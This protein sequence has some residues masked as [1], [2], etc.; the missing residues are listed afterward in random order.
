MSAATPVAIA[1][2]GWYITDTADKRETARDDA[3]RRETR[4]IVRY[5]KLID[6]RVELWDKL[7]PELAYI[8][9]HVRAHGHGIPLDN[10]D[11]SRRVNE[12]NN[13]IIA[14]EGYF[15][16]DLIRAYNQFIGSTLPVRSGDAS[17]ENIDELGKKYDRLVEV[18]RHELEIVREPHS[19]SIAAASSSDS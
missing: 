4:E 17:K 11:I 15:S 8:W 10:D 16:N 12:T 9:R 14:Y 19:D 7:A 5:E 13:L 2:M 1:L 3:I 6:K 18:V